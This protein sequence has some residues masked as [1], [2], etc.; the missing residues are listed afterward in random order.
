MKNV[1]LGN[2]IFTKFYLSML[3]CWQW[4]CWYV[5]MLIPLCQV[6]NHVAACACPAGY[7]GNAISSCYR[8]NWR[9]RGLSNCWGYQGRRN[10]FI[11]SGPTCWLVAWLVSS[12]SIKVS[13]LS[14]MS[15]I[16]SSVLWFVPLLHHVKWLRLGICLL[17]WKSYLRISHNGPNLHRQQQVQYVFDWFSHVDI[18]DGDDGDCT[19][20]GGAKYPW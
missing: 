1:F 15:E 13:K 4:Q 8:L 7:T 19:G 10:T 9:L 3:Q 12:C 11:I 5:D 16:K 17:R 6:V 14:F 18:G 20:A 2:Q